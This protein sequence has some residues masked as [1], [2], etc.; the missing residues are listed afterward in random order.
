ML[1]PKQQRFVLEYLSNGLNATQA[2]I[3]AGYSAK[4]AQVQGSRLLSHVMVKEAVS[5]AKAKQ[6]ATAT[7]ILQAELGEIEISAARTLVEIARVGYVDRRSYYHE[8]GRPKGMHELTPAQGAALADVE[9]LVRNVTAGDGQSDL[10]HKFKL[11][12]KNKA[13]QMLA[14][15]FGLLVEK[16]QVSGDISYKWGE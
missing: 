16:V 6:V 12:D 7:Q 13:L 9:L 10:V 14:Q 4:T 5:E 15:H 1:T 11:W 2:A 3:K 8:D